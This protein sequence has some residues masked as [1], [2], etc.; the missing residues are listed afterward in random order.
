MK[1]L[2]LTATFLTLALP[3]TALAAGGA[4]RGVVLSV[5]PARHTVE[6]VDAHHVVHS[7]R[8]RG[9]IIGVRAG[10]VVN[11]HRSG[12]AIAGIRV[13]GSARVVSYYARVVRTAGKHVVLRLA[14]GRTVSF[15]SRA[16]AK[17]TKRTKRTK[18]ARKA[19]ARSASASAPAVTVNIQ[20]LTPG[21]TV[22]VTE[23]V[24]PDGTI[25]ISITLPAAGS[26]STAGDQTVDGV[27]SD[28]QDDTFTIST[29]DGSSLVLHMNA[30]ALGA[31]DMFSCD[32]V[33]VSYHTDAGLLVADNVDDTGTSSSGDCAGD[34]GSSDET[35]PIV[36]LSSTSVTIATQDQGNMTFSVDPTAGLTDGFLVGDV[37]DVT[38]A[39]DSSGANAASDI[40]YVESDATGVV[41]AVGAGTISFTDGQTGATDGFTADPSQQLFDGV[42]VGDQV[43]VTYH[44]SSGQPV[45]DNVDD[46]TADGSSGGGS[47]G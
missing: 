26:G 7:L 11:F 1:R 22:L 17:R 30:D 13:A 37:V 19:I 16:A 42:T 38:Y 9:R 27:V 44:Q 35:G 21:A 10:S 23:T 2:T 29:A 28:V 36:S 18:H 4:D 40:E 33:T 8:Y 3:A 6:L 12:A 24:A 47:G 31:L 32:T 14:D 34:S 5:N 20:G 39:A 41:T 43:D 46:L 25:T 45:V 15:A